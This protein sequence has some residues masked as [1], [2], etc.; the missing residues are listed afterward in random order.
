MSQQVYDVIVQYYRAFGLPPTTREICSLAGLAATST[1]HYHLRKLA[2]MGL[3]KRVRF[4]YVP[5]E[6]LDYLKLFT[7]KQGVIHG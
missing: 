1:A 2:K 4:Q 7:P 3:L 5:V 6:A